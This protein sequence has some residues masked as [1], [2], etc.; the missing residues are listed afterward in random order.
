MVIEGSDQ[1]RG[2]F[3]ASLVLSCAD[4]STPP[5]K[6]V[7]THG[8]VVDKHGDKMSK[9]LG[10]VT[11]PLSIVEKYGADTLRL[12][13]LNATP[14]EDLRLSTQVLTS[15]QTQLKRF[16]LT[17]RY[18]LGII[19]HKAQGEVDYLPLEKWVLSRL[20]SVDAEWRRLVDAH[21]TGCAIKMLYKFCDEELSGLYLDVRK[22]AL[23]CDS[24][25][26]PKY[27]SYAK[28]IEQVFQHLVRWL[29]PAAPFLTE[30]AWQ[31]HPHTS[32]SVHVLDAMPIGR[33]DTELELRYSS[34]LQLRSIVYKHVEQLRCDKILNTSHAARVVVG[35]DL[36]CKLSEEEMRELCIVSEFKYSDTS[37]TGIQV[38]QASGARC[39]RCRF[40]SEFSG[41][42]CTRCT[43]ALSSN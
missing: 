5:Y 22:D 33:I 30:E 38:E 7:L 9:S 40:Y 8:F 11:D 35:R 41:G 32:G 26:D 25:D 19:N 39:P 18:M 29:S 3:Q 28:C 10:N 17:L 37:A 13:I 23:Y 1:H 16:R 12:M 21:Q 15:A 20:A 4:S 2:W 36:A 27:R 24:P 14:Y 34:A 42:Y 31:H 6:K 43:E